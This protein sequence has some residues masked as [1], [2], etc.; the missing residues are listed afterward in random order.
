M[1]GK[2]WSR[3]EEVYFWRSV[4]PVSPKAVIETGLRYTWAE[5][6]TRMKH[7]FERLGQRPRRQYTKLMLF[8]HY[9]QNVET[10]H[11]SPHGKDLVAEHKWQLGEPVLP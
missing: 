3:D 9:Y 11:K 10:G 8:E 7:Y 2:T 5:C 4:V 6:A 1:G